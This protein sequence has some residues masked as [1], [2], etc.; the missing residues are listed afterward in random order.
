MNIHPTAVV[1]PDAK[2]GNNVEIGP[3]SIIEDNVVIGDGCFIDA[4]VKVARRNNFV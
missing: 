4:H 2:L 3:Y 1:S